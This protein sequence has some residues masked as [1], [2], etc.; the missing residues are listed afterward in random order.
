MTECQEIAW[1]LA[2]RKREFASM[3]DVRE[4]VRNQMCS[5]ESETVIDNVAWA[6]YRITTNG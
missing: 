3:D 5:D 4:F 1:V 2:K 6:L